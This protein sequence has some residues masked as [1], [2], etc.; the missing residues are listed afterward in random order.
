MAFAFARDDKSVE[1][2]LRRLA[3]ERLGQSLDLVSAPAAAAGDPVH[4]LRKNIKKT[5]ALLRLLRPCFDD[6]AAENAALRDAARLLGPLREQAVLV[7]TLKRL[8]ADIAVAP[9]DCTALAAALH[10]GH[11]VAADAAGIL[12]DHA[13]RIAAI[14]KRARHWRLDRTGPAAGGFAAIAPGLERS[15]SAAQK[16]MQR[17]LRRHDAEALH[18][19]RKRVKD[20]WYHARLLAPIW[21][22]MMAP[23][24]ALAGDLGEML[25]DARD[26]ALLAAA[27]A[28]PGLADLPGATEIGAR[29]DAEAARL[30]DLA[31]LDG[32]RLLAEPA[33]GLSRRWQ[34]WW[35]IWRD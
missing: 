20:H 26:S 16:A 33:S 24:I 28:R 19:W 23:H 31:R 29:A 1:Q 10:A 5:R 30:A 13:R 22:A 21:P 12:K 4:E 25:G 17:S 34:G 32:K 14:R 27:L 15:W 2:A 18:L 35:E 6:F 7:A 8:A 3:R 11:P 9:A